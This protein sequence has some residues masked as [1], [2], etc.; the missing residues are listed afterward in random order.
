MSH[1]GENFSWVGAF[2]ASTVG[3]RKAMPPKA[4]KIWKQKINKKERRLAIRSGLSASV[5]EI[6]VRERG[7]KFEK[8]PSVVASDLEKI[9]KTRDLIRVL[10]S[11]GLSGELERISKSKVRA[12]VGKTR[13]RKYR[14][15]KGPLFVVAENCPLVKA[16]LNIKGVDVTI[17]D[18]L[19]T[20]LLAPGCHPGRL[21]I[22]TDKAIERMKKENLFYEKVK[23]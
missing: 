11:M 20:E 22:Y 7:H 9:N 6:L 13:G 5:N 23:K 14:V 3:G 17:V 15:K 18:K 19:N 8:L 1:T 21:T 2:A 10:E 16:A 4:D 12:G